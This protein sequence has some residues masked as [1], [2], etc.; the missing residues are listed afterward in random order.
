VRK[1]DVNTAIR[2]AG[3]RRHSLGH[4]LCLYVRGNSALWVYQYRDRQTKRLRQTSLGSAK[5]LMPMNLS[6]AREAHMRFRISLLDGTAPAQRAPQGKSFAE[7][8]HAYLAAKASTLKGGH[9]GKEAK[10]Y[11]RLLDL[12]FAQMPLTQIGH[13][14]VRAA[15]SEWDGMATASKFRTKIASVID[16]ATAHG[17]YVGANPAAAK[18]MGKILPA[19]A[20]V[21]NHPAMD[22]RNLPAF[23]AHLATFDTPASRAL[24]F[25]ILCAARAGETLGATWSEIQ[26]DVW[27]IGERM[28]E[29][30]PHSAPLAPQAIALL[31]ERGQPDELIFK[32]TPTG[33]RAKRRRTAN[34][35][36][37]ELPEGAMREY[38][39]GKP[40]TTK[41]KDA[42][43]H[44]FRST[45][46]DWA[47]ENG[48]PFE[49]GELAIAHTVGNKSTR[50]YRRT[51]MLD[52]RR[53]MMES[54]AN[55]ATS[56]A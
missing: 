17:W 52:Q 43:V 39:K 23:M 28:K 44:G 11:Q 30:K 53:P 38:V 19:T 3:N 16:F 20:R 32:S 10:Q 15:L 13:D 4:G 18:T 46:T 5:G 26:G 7:A 50:A 24:R 40:S 27:A 42:T 31:G 12:D 8:L 36:A 2:G 6:E 29:G 51:N 56:A 22:W 41:G 47:A 21:Q 37:G 25:T 45:F 34:V 54:W 55:F 9:D 48:Y 14:A 49:L 1:F 35:S 33:A